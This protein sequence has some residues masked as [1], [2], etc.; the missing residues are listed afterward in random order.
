VLRE[1]LRVTASSTA[2]HPFTYLSGCLFVSVCL[3]RAFIFS[4]TVHVVFSLVI[5][6]SIWWVCNRKRRYSAWYY[7]VYQN[8]ET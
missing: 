2:H 6:S 1:M 8:S 3:S 7:C 4:I 5:S